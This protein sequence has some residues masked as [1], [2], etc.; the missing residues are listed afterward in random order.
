[1]VMKKIPKNIKALGSFTFPIQICDSNIFNAL[2][3]LMARISLMPLLVFNT[4]WLGKPR[5]CSV[6]LHMTYSTQVCSRRIINNMLIKVSKICIP[7]D[8]IIFIMM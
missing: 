2:V 4:I 6:V 5:P 1:M 7:I 3:D 8:F